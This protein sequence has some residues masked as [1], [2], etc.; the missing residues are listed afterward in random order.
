MSDATFFA[1]AN[2]RKRERPLN[3]HRMS[4]SFELKEYCDGNKSDLLAFIE[5]RGLRE[6]GTG[7]G[8]RMVEEVE[9]L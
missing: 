8:F 9:H 3:K 6:H 2:G 7:V 4:D 5:G 1:S